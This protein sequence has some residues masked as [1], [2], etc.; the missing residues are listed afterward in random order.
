MQGENN[1]REESSFHS[2]TDQGDHQ[3]VPNPVPYLRRE[4]NPGECPPFLQGLFMGAGGLQGLLCGEG[5]A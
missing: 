1:D 2:R 4:G 3:E 5:P